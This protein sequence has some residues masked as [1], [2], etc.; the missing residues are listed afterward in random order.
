MLSSIAA[1]RRS[2]S[3]HRR[4]T[5]YL[6]CIWLPLLVATL[7]PEE[8]GGGVSSAEAKERVVGISNAGSETC[9]GGPRR[10]VRFWVGANGAGGVGIVN[11]TTNA[12]CSE[13]FLANLT[14]YRR[15]V[16]SIGVEVWK[17]GSNASGP[18]LTLNDG[19]TRDDG[20]A[21]CLRQVKQLFNISVGVCGTTDAT[22]LNVGAANP[23]AF[24]AAV[25]EFL[26]AMPFEVDEL[27]TGKPVSHSLTLNWLCADAYA[28]LTTRCSDG[29]VHRFRSQ[30]DW[31][32]HTER[33]K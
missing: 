33:R 27:W 13:Y 31:L 11:R 18:V 24:A 20:L 32:R 30:A 9:A 14:K 23:M 6:Y 22:H 19:S 1:T 4:V 3:R 28:R 15:S 7:L 5:C 12:S 21:A 16:D 10:K 2:S 29:R 8:L 25:R 17:L 26:A